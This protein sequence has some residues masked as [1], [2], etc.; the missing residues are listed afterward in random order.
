M[1]N[2]NSSH[3]LQ[4]FEYFLEEKAQAYFPGHSRLNEAINYSLLSGGKRIR[5]LFCLG[6]AQLFQGQLD[7]ALR[8][9]MAIEMVHA[10]SLIHDDLPSM[11][12]DDMRRGRPTNHKV[13]GEAHA[14]LAGDALITAAPDILMRELMELKVPAELIIKITTTLLEASG[15]EGMIKG[16][17]LDMEAE[18]GM[19]PAENQTILLKNIHQNKTGQLFRWS[20]LSGLYSCLQTETIEKN[21][22]VVSQLGEKFGLLFQIVDDILDET[23][24]LKELGKTPGKD[25]KS[26]KLTYVQLYGISESKKMAHAISDEIQKMLD[27]FNG[28]SDVLG[29][30]LLGLKEKISR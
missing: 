8:C 6:A 21:E 4:Q 27:Q 24:T 13:Y 20:C 7:V 17:A 11:D 28:S 3:Y 10:Y 14:I 22:L 16:Q 5:P 1:T 12:N 30:M 15:H 9:A 18:Q 2:M 26:G 23:S 29:E 19:F 25:K